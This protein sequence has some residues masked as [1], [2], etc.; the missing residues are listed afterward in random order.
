MRATNSMDG[1]DREGNGETQRLRE[2]PSSQPARGDDGPTTWPTLQ[3]D[4]SPTKLSLEGSLV[5][6]KISHRRLFALPRLPGSLSSID[7]GA[8]AE[9]DSV[10]FRE[11]LNKLS[12]ECAE[13]LDS[14]GDLY[15]LSQELAE[16]NLALAAVEQRFVQP[17]SI[18]PPDA[19]HSAESAIEALG[20]LMEISAQS[21]KNFAQRLQS[22]NEA[23]ELANSLAAD[24][25]AAA[26]QDEGRVSMMSPGEPN[27]KQRRPSFSSSTAGREKKRSV[28]REVAKKVRFFLARLSRQSNAFCDIHL[29]LLRFF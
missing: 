20:N 11:N 23:A 14:M 6:P 28:W 5:S 26:A 21:R 18:T 17:P 12:G 1:S 10:D 24:G 29:L 27:Q 7:D 22:L 15:G 19:L 25:A 9:E 3:F 2:R 8:V 16:A 13:K 4:R